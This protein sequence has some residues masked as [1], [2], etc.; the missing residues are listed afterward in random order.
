M[1]G[2]ERETNCLPIGSIK[3]PVG[4]SEVKTPIPLPLSAKYKKNLSY[5]IENYE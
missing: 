3:G 5:Q 2:V 4:E 1:L